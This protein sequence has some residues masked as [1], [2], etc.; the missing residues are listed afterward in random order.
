MIQKTRSKQSAQ[1]TVPCIALNRDGNKII[2]EKAKDAES[3]G[4]NRLWSS[5]ASNAPFAESSVAQ[6]GK[7]VNKK[8]DLKDEEYVRAVESGDE[9][10]AQRMVDEAAEAAGYKPVVRYHQTG[11]EFTEFSTDNPDAGANDDETPN[12]IFFKENDHDIGVGGDYVKTGHG[13]SVQ[14][15]VF[16]KSENAMNMLKYALD[17]ELNDGHGIFYIDQK[18]ANQLPK[19]AQINAAIAD[20]LRALG[21]EGSIHSIKDSGGAVKVYPKEQNQTQQFDRW[22]GNSE[23]STERETE[24]GEIERIPIVMYHGTASDFWAFDIKKSNDMTGRRLGLGAGANKI[25]LTEY[26]ASAKM[27]ASGAKSRAKNGQERVLG[28]YVSAQKVM[29]RAEYNRRLEEAYKK[30]PNS[31]PHGERYDYRARDKAVS[32]VDKQVKAEGY[33]GV[34]DRESGEMFVYDPTQVKSATDNIGTFDRKNP[35]I[36]Y[37]LKDDAQTRQDQEALEDLR[38]DPD[39]YAQAMTDEET[40]EAVRLFA[41][42]YRNLENASNDLGTQGTVL[43]VGSKN[44]VKAI[45]TENRPLCWKGRMKHAQPHHPGHRAAPRGLPGA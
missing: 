7:T 17:T 34:W 9:E 13:G 31:D 42:I 23:V 43:R 30:Y 10:T 45:S 2:Y 14:M 38:E 26:E 28:L 41:K 44:Q 12:G 16:L 39:F 3:R 37:D 35:D 40:A 29:D 22:F 15:P 32:E 24:D 25:Y 11:A 19:T 21:K 33:D 20:R 27:A 4:S 8:F 6:E 36:R 5:L 18:R 1:R